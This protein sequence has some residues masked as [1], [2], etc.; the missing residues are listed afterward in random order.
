VTYYKDGEKHTIRRRP[1]LKLHDALPGD[2]VILT[3]GKNDDF[4]DGDKLKVKSIQPR[5][6]NTLQLAN[7]EG[8]ATFVEYYDTQ[9]ITQPIDRLHEGRITRDE[10]KA[11]GIDLSI[12]NKYLLWP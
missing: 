2:T 7:E 6:P 3:R 11:Q 10:A 9:L 12:D 5:S 1:P 4:P 8:M